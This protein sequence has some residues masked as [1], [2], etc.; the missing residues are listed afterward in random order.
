MSE[1]GFREPMRS[2]KHA[3][4]RGW[5]VGGEADSSVALST[6]FKLLWYLCLLPFYCLYFSN[7]A[8]QH[9]LVSRLVPRRYPRHYRTAG[10]GLGVMFSY[11]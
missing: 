2:F 5:G 8:A 9:V 3:R 11:Y 4:D 7:V 6:A 10:G 1:F